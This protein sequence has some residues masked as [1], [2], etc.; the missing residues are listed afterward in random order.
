MHLA[1]AVDWFDEGGFEKVAVHATDESDADP[2]GALGFALGVVA[3]RTK[4]FLFHLG[5]HVFDSFESLGL[6]LRQHAKV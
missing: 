3:A 1:S 4:T 6:A 5:G 2:F